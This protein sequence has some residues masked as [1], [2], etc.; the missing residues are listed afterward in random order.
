[1]HLARNENN[2]LTA[3]DRCP[4][5]VQHK[6]ARKRDNE[7]AKSEDDER[8]TENR[9]HEQKKESARNDQD[10]KQKNKKQRDHQK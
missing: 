6:G 4:K 8:K 9:V 10:G 2:G 5:I 3:R 1:M 7:R